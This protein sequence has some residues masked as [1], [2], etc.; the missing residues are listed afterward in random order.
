MCDQVSEPEPFPFSL[1]LV[2]PLTAP[3]PPPPSPPVDFGIN[4][5]GK[6]TKSLQTDRQTDRQTLGIS[7]TVSQ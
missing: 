3:P 5:Q 2:N 4:A 1:R 6:S 7:V